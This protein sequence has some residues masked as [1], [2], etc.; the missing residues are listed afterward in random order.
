ME[1]STD[2]SHQC[3][4]SQQ[5]DG[6]RDKK[7]RL[8]RDQETLG[9]TVSRLKFFKLKNADRVNTPSVTGLNFVG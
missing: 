3:P 7:D 5:S 1:V 9:E 6:R 2:I 4:I 8:S